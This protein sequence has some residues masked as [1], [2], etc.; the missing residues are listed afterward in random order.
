MRSNLDRR[1]PCLPPPNPA[2]RSHRSLVQTTALNSRFAPA[3]CGGN[4]CIQRLSRVKQRLPGPGKSRPP[5][6]KAMP[7]DAVAKGHMWP[8]QLKLNSLKLSE[9]KEIQFFGHSSHISS[10]PPPYTPLDMLG[11][12]HRAS[13]AP[14]KSCQR[15]VLEAP[16]GAQGGRVFPLLAGGRDTIM[17]VTILINNDPGGNRILCLFLTPHGSPDCYEALFLGDPP[18]NAQSMLHEIIK[19][20]KW[21]V[22]Q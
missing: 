5:A 18:P 12:A 9:R 11:H 4:K 19:K 3:V 21:G 22:S 14:R 7:P 6:I 17:E 2:V 16:P 1:G 10:L 13:P 15:A 8:V 20:E